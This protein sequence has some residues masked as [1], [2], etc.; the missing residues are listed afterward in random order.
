MTAEKAIEIIKKCKEKKFK[1]TIY[2]VNEYEAAMDMAIKA[3]RREDTLDCLDAQKTGGSKDHI[4]IT[5]EVKADKVMDF[6][7]EIRT[8]VLEEVLEIIDLETSDPSS[9]EEGDEPMSYAAGWMACGFSIK[10]KVLALK[11]GK[12]E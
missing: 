3:L 9:G 8:E 10:D 12:Q 5:V 4:E 7:R 2:T 6:T 1:H 11:G